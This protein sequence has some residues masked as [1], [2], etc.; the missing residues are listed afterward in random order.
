MLP[1][2]LTEH[3]RRAAVTPFG[4]EGKLLPS[5]SAVA[6]N[7][8]K[9]NTSK[10]AGQRYWYMLPD[11][12]PRHKPDL[13]I[14]RVNSARPKAVLNEQRGALVDANFATLWL[15]KPDESLS[16]MLLAYLSSTLAWTIF[17]FVG[18]VMGGGALKL[19]ATHLASF[20]VPKFTPKAKA[21][22][23]EL[24]AKLCQHDSSESA[25]VRAAIDQVVCSEVVGNKNWV[26]GLN[27]LKSMAQTKLDARRFRV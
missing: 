23:T 25:A 9:S 13:F 19:E 17:E 26:L 3:I 16:N 2:E 11:F 15:T 22:L 6:T 20:P 12:A 18:A 5:L 1:A 21:K 14:A 24:G 7:V 27:T 8:R 4:D 10:G